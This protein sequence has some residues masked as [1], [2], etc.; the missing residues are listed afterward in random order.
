MFWLSPLTREGMRVDNLTS[1]IEMDLYRAL[2]FE[3]KSIMRTYLSLQ[4]TGNYFF[5]YCNLAS[6]E[7]NLQSSQPQ[8]YSY[9]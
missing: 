5:I 7:M 9:K 3:V 2:V 1:T 8:S 6:L 4:S